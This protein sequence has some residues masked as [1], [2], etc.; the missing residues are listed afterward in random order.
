MPYCDNA[1]VRIHYHL[2]GNPDGFP[3]VLQVSF[4]LSLQHWYE[5]GTWP[6]SARLAG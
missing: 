5:V 6:P 3:V 4:S 1:G 2:E